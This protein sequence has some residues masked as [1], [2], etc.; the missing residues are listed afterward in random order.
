MTKPVLGHFAKLVGTKSSS[1]LPTDVINFGHFLRGFLQEKVQQVQQVAEPF[2]YVQ[3]A[4]GGCGWGTFNMATGLVTWNFQIGPY[5]SVAL[6]LYSL[7]IYNAATGLPYNLDTMVITRNGMPLG[8]QI[9]GNSTVWWWACNAECGNDKDNPSCSLSRPS[10]RSGN[11]ISFGKCA[12]LWMR[13]VIGREVEDT[14]QFNISTLGLIC[15]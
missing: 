12:P 14:S 10:I 1:I 7:A 2:I 6:N 5:A 11:P 3:I 13:R 15:C 9:A 8:A 4:A